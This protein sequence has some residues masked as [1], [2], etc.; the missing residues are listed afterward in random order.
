MFVVPPR[1]DSA[2]QNFP[3]EAGFSAKRP[4]CHSPTTGK[5]VAIYICSICQQFAYWRLRFIRRMVE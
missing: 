3:G 2:T 4:D 5:P 1:T